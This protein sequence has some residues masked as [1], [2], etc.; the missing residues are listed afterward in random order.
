M[1]RED[2]PAHSLSSNAFHRIALTICPPCEIR[3]PY[4]FQLWINSIIP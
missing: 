1:S 3:R 2:R 4:C